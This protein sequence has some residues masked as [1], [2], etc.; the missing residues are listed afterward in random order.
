MF[1]YLT[2][3]YS[4]LIRP[5]SMIVNSICAN[6][7][8]CQ[9]LIWNALLHV[10]YSDEFDFDWPNI[11]IFE[12]QKRA[13]VSMLRLKKSDEIQPNN[14]LLLKR[15]MSMMRLRRGLGSGARP[16]RGPSMMRLKRL[17]LVK[18]MEMDTICS[19]YPE[20]CW[21]KLHF[22]YWYWSSL[23]SFFLWLWPLLLDITLM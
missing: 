9:F 1:W 18:D 14:D 4:V 19:M 8:Y 10:C 16:V 22:L 20:Y 11:A 21:R 6:F 5:N 17:P 15:A 7:M 23:P 13:G 2:C 12:L 3:C